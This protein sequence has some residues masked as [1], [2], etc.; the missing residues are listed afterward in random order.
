MDVMVGI[1]FGFVAWFIVQY[2]LGGFYS[3]G[4]DERAVKTVFGRAERLG[5]ATTLDD[6]IAVFLSDEERQRYR[7]LQL[8]VIPPGGL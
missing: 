3:V 6:P 5:D 2:G 4:P 1:F 8:R 7:Y